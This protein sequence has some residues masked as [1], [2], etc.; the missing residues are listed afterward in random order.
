MLIGSYLSVLG[1]KRRTAIPK[2]FLDELGGQLVLA[3]WYEDCL[4]LVKK[5]FNP[6]FK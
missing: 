1:E 2:K 6:G 5:D 3:K 4:V